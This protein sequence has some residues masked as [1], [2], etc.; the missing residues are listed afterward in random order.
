MFFIGTT[1]FS[2]RNTLDPAPAQTTKIKQMSIQNGIYDQVFVSKNPDLSVESGYDPWDFDTILNADYSDGTPDAGNCGFSLHNTDYVIIKKR[3]K[4][5]MDWMTIFAREIHTVED[6]YI[7]IKDFFNPNGA[8]LDYMLVSVCNGIE[9]SYVLKDVTS[10][11][12]GM[13][14]CDRDNIYGTIYDLDYMDTTVNNSSQVIELLNS[15]YPAVVS[16]SPTHY[17]SST[18]VGSF[19]RFDQETQRVEVNAGIDYRDN[20]K[21]WLNNRKPKVLKFY[22][23]RIW[24]I[25]ISGPVSDAGRDHNDLRQLSFEW[26][27]IGNVN[28]MKSMYE[29]GLSDID[30]KWW[31]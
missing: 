11:F 31:Y 26:V 27:E 14:I 25:R 15:R 4:G 12:E 21:Q 13:C 19:I 6:F 8:E 17:E 18:A 29:C 28:D 7:H 3:K 24:L 23:G 5:T 30:R 10:C 16:N 22:D 9:N 1:F 20:V 2:G